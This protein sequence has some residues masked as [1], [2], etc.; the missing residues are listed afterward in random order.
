MKIAITASNDKGLEANID[1]RFG[2]AP[3]F[4]IVDTDTMEVNTLSNAGSGASH[5]AGVRAAQIIADQG[6]DGVISGN[7]GPKAC[8]GLQTAGVRLYSFKNGTVNDAVDALKNNELD[9]ISGPTS[10]S[11]SGLR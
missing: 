7:F 11:H 1:V 8:S 5:G 2:R 3:Y 10:K 6:V 9:E 4:A